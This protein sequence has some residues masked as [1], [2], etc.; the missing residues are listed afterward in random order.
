MMRF[1]FKLRPVVCSNSSNNLLHFHVSKF[2]I[3]PLSILSKPSKFLSSKKTEE[4]QVKDQRE[5]F[6]ALFDEI[7]EILGTEGVVSDKNLSGFP[8]PN[9]EPH[10]SNNEMRE[11][12]PSYCPPPVCENVNL[13]KEIYSLCSEDTQSRNLS[14][15]D[16][17]SIVH[18]VTEIVRGENGVVS[19]EKRLEE[20]GFELDL[21][22]VE[23]VLKRCFKV[24]H[25]A[26][27]FFNWVKLRDGFCHTTETYHTMIYIAGEAKEFGV[28]EELV[29]EMETNSCEKDVRTWTILILHY[30][31]AKLIGKALLIFEKMKKLGIEPDAVVYKL[32]LRLLCFAGKAD[33]AME[34]YKE[35]VNKEMGVDVNL[36]RLLFTCLAKCGDINLVHLV[37][38]DM[39][40]ISQIPEHHVH[41]CVLKSFCISGRIKEAL[42]LIRDLKT[43]NITLEPEHFETLVKGLCRSDRIGDALEI[44]DIMKKRNV[45]D[46]KIYGLLVNGYLRRNDISKAFDAFESIKE[47]GNLPTISTYTE[48]MQHCFRLNEFEKASALYNEILEK[49]IELDIVAVTAIVAGHVRQNNVSEAWAVFKSMEERGIKATRKFY[50]IFIKELCKISRT[51]EIVKVLNEMQA[52]EVIIGDELFR[53]IV[54]Y[55]EKKKEMDKVETVKNM[56]RACRLYYHQATEPSSSSDLSR[57]AELNSNQL[58]K[59]GLELD[60]HPIESQPNSYTDHDLKEICG[61]LSSSMDWYPK[62]EALEKSC[63]RF[64]PQLVVEILRNC[65]RLSGGSALHFF[66]WVGN[67]AGFSH[68]TETYNMAIKISGQ[69]KDFKHMRSLFYEM[70]RKGCLV[71]PDTWTIMI[72]QYGQTCLTEIA[73]KNFRE[74]KSS[75]CAPNGST[76]KSLIT[77]LCAKKGRKVNEAIQTFEEMIRAGFI[78]DKELAE[79]Y[80]TCL[81]EVDKLVNA[82]H[83]IEYLRNVGFSVPLSYSLHIRALCRCGKVEEALALVDE[84]GEEQQR[85]T[86]NQYI[87]GSLVHGLLRKRQL[88]D[89][90]AKIESM[91]RVGVN[92]TV[93]VYTSLIVYFFKEKEMDKAMEIFSKMKEEG[94]EPTIVTYSALIRGYTS[95]GK[96]IEAWG[97][98]NNLKKKGP[99]P[100]FKTYSM[101]ISCLCRVGKSEEALQLISEMLD[102]GIV[103]STVNFQTV[104]YG[105]NREG[106]QKLAT[107]V[108]QR[109][110]DLKSRRK[111]LT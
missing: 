89:A 63:V 58:E 37:A 30:A 43:K 60:S 93:H 65:S 46:G 31:K 16:V 48:L 28:V 80:L 19:M 49:G 24:P 8:I 109:K 51:D 76:Y 55:L 36:Y 78:P 9:T 13:E 97:V 62:K 1:L 103:P 42:E 75:S 83:C 104:I 54:S 2:Q 110:L 73:L 18:K 74:M 15:S 25:L 40:K 10:L 59:Q 57:S 33:I 70:R 4:T 29:E 84:V 56:Q 108:L 22:I 87:Y 44:V 71:T 77:S 38:D 53:W 92:P 82:R 26:L 90:L 86:L 34:F 11:D 105:L 47:S 107:T 79:T 61:I 102:T 96:I 66:L 99:L 88:E 5:T 67:Q 45:V 100:D 52:S 39:I 35:M 3:S 68:T 111:Y 32:M 6:T 27:R 20:A 94:C 69:G 17:S 12:H 91:K 98:F 101:F 23:K 41:S 95:M 72:T 85:K 21:E 81:C 14:E 50:T 64:T 7:T 106:K